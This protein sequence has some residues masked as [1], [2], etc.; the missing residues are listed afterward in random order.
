MLFM[1][2]FC[3][4][5]ICI[6][7]SYN[8]PTKKNNFLSKQLNNRSNKF[9]YQIN[10]WFNNFGNDYS[11]IRNNKIDQLILTVSRWPILKKK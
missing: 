7:I 8:K 1:N 4:L 2:N 3:Q 5:Y 10:K 9:N 11:E 6:C